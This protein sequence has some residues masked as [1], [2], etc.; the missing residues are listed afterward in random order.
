MWITPSWLLHNA[1]V[2]LPAVFGCG[3]AADIVCHPDS[4]QHLPDTLAFTDHTQPSPAVAFW[5]EFKKKTGDSH[6]PTLQGT[7]WF[8]SSHDTAK[9]TGEGQEHEGVAK[10]AETVDGGVD[11]ASPNVQSGG[12]SVLKPGLHGEDTRLKSESDREE[13]VI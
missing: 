10:I 5:E 3:V 12:A 4:A 9:T 11:D 13:T 1:S 8:D 2:V 7:D 6:R